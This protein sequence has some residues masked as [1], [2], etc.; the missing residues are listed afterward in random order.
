M[1]LI[2]MKLEETNTMASHNGSEIVLDE[3][4]LNH[5]KLS[6]LRVERENLKTKE[7][8]NEEMVEAIRKIIVDEVNKNY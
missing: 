7:R 5:M 4:K 1:P 3:K 6:I 8:T 2:S